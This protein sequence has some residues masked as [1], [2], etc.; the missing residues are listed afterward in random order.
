MKKSILD[1]ELVN[2]PLAGESEGEH[3]A[4]CGGLDD[5]TECLDKVIAWTLGETT[6]NPTCILAL[7]RTV[8]KELVLEDPLLGENVGVLSR[9]TEQGPHVVTQGSLVETT[10]PHMAW[11]PCRDVQE[12][13][14]WSRMAQHLRV[15]VQEILVASVVQGA[16]AHSHEGVRQ[17]YGDGPWVREFI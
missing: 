8:S 12:K 16:A 7:Q 5:E 14:G 13:P 2:G 11:S 15:G 1:V 6:K 9:C 10:V 3:C 4:N 17:P